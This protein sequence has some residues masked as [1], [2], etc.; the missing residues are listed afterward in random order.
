MSL[1]RD[2]LLFSIVLMLWAVQIEANGY[3]ISGAIVFTSLGLGLFGL[4]GSFISSLNA[5][6]PDPVSGSS[7]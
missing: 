6:S 7:E 3:G 5:V 1:S 2:V 4:I